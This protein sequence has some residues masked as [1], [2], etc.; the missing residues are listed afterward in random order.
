MNDLFWVPGGNP[1]LKSESGVSAE[2]GAVWN[3]QLSPN[4]KLE[5]KQAVF[6]NRVNNW[7]LWTPGISYWTPEN[8]TKVHSRGWEHQ[9]SISFQKNALEIVFNSAFQHV[10]SKPISDSN[11]AN[12]RLQLIYVPEFGWNQQ[13]A[14]HYKKSKLLLSGTYTGKRYTASDNSNSLPAFYVLNATLEQRLSA[15]ELNI[16]IFLQLNNILNQDYQVLQQRPMP[17]IHA[18]LGLSFSFNN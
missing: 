2:V 17:L 15:Q 3:K 18:Q 7:I 8:L 12:K 13:I 16:D 6:S 9:L 14:F 4:W 1:D 10:R 5:S 11:P